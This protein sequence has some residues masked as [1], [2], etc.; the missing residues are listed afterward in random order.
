MKLMDFSNTM[1][2]DFVFIFSQFFPFQKPISPAVSP[3]NVHC[4]VI[5]DVLC[6]EKSWE[7]RFNG[8]SLSKETS[9]E[10]LVEVLSRQMAGKEG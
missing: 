8:I 3:N 5:A 4:V 10:H 7:G 1:T 6:R 2:N 9:V